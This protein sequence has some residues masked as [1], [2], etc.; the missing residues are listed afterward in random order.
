MKE[1][2]AQTFTFLLSNLHSYRTLGMQWLTASESLL[3]GIGTQLHWNESFPSSFEH[4][5]CVTIC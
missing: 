3:Q 4:G 1:K 5:L 2:C